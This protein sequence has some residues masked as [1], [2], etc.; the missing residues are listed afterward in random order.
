MAEKEREA[1]EKRL[2]KHETAKREQE[3]RLAKRRRMMVI[4]STNKGLSAEKVKNIVRAARN[5]MGK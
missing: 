5:R 1:M 4:F 2:A 3:K